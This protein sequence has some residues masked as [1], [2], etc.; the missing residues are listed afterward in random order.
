[1]GGLYFTSANQNTECIYD[2]QWELLMDQTYYD[3]DDPTCFIRG[4]TV[5]SNNS[6]AFFA[7]SGSALSRGGAGNGDVKGVELPRGAF[8]IAVAR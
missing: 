4:I 2:S 6:R 7:V 1:M 8:L 5:P 3:D